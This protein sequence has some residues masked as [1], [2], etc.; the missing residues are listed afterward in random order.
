[1]PG[2]NPITNIGGPSPSFPPT[3]WTAIFEARRH[4]ALDY[5]QRL[6]ELIRAYWKPI[7]WTLRSRW[8]QPNEDAKDLTQAFFASFLE[9]DKLAH[10]DPAKGRF[11]AFL[12]VTLDNFM[13]NELEAAK[14]QKRGGGRTVLSLDA[15]DEAPPVASEDLPP[16]EMFD[17]AWA[18]HVFGET[19]KDL[20]AFYEGSGRAD[21]FQ[22]FERHQL[23]R[24]PPSAA[25]LA[26]ELGVKTYEI[27]NRLKHARA[28][29]AKRLRARVKET[30]GTEGDIEDELRALA[31][32]MA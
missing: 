25:K 19:V 16:D 2:N 1:M 13:R 15:V 9:K 30:I 26:E 8:R 21:W 7:Y 11:R 5:R 24:E 14:A 22:V 18:V 31:K 12:R 10:V 4:S 20:K 32:A 27:E 28:E 3:L 23:D 29:F 6:D 17:R